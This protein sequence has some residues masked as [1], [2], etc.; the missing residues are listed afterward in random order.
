M[1]HQITKAFNFRADN[2]TAVGLIDNDFKAMN[3]NMYHYSK[4]ILHS[5]LTT[6]VTPKGSP[7]QVYK[8]A[9]I[10]CKLSLHQC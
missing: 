2:G 5:Q 1:K 10:S 7:L 4:E 9:V 3:P 8:C 6:Y